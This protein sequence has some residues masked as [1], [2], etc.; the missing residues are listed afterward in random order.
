[1][2]ISN[3]K[4]SDMLNRSYLNLVNLLK[5]FNLTISC[6]ESCTGGLISK[7]LTDVSGSSQIFLGSLI[8]YSNEIKEN[9]LNV[10]KE[11]LEEYGAVSLET[12]IEMCRG[13]NICFNSSISVSTTGIAGPSGATENKPVGMVCFG[14]VIN[15]K[16]FQEVEFFSGDRNDIR[17]FSALFVSEFIMER[18][19]S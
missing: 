15:G 7:L 10:E 17:N 2:N 4:I 5:E 3:E 11:T 16:E 19:S 9:F 8:A 14:F 6:A 1:M 18:L 12:A 13:I